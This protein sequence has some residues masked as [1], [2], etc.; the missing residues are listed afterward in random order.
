MEIQDHFGYSYQGV[1]AEGADGISQG[2][3]TY[4]EKLHHRN[5]KYIAT[6]TMI[7]LFNL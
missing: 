1:H 7:A 4:T 6:L 3:L 2:R 5:Q